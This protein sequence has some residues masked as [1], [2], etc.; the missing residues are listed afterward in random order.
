MTEVDAIR[1]LQAGGVLAFALLVLL[2][3]QRHLV[4]I[5]RVMEASNALATRVA[6]ALENLAGQVREVRD[7]VTP[8][9]RPAPLRTEYMHRRRK[10]E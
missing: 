7:D 1:L 10:D 3:L 6:V 2:L 8:P 4:R 5:E 9:A